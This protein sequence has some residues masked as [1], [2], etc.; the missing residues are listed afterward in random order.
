MSGT[1]GS[2][3]VL[4]SPNNETSY[5]HPASLLF[6]M[7]PRELYHKYLVFN[8]KI[9]TKKVSKVFLNLVHEVMCECAVNRG[10]MWSVSSIS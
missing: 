9:Q 10:V 1:T 2:E 3:T 6:K 5:L 7:P 8:E 4:K